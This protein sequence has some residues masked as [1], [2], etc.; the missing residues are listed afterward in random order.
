MTTTFLFDLL[1]KIDGYLLIPHELM[2]VA[3]YR[4]IGKRCAYSVGDH[5]VTALEPRSFKERLFCLLFPLAINL[6]A[7]LV[8]LLGWCITYIWLR[9]PLYPI[10]YLQI[11]P[12]WHQVLLG[13]WLILLLYASS[14]TL[15][16]LRVIQLIM[17]KLSQQPPYDPSEDR[18]EWQPP[19]HRNQQ[20]A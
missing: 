3:A 17:E 16:M 19:Q 8:L 1:W 14:C 2:H 12:M 7:A 6:V 10:D 5:T 11:A 13:S 18:N 4:M 9:Y 15:D 20:H